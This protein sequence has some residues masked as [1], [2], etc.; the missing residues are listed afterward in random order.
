MMKSIRALV[1]IAAAIS[2]FAIPALADPVY[3]E[4]DGVS[5]EAYFGLLF[6]PV[7]IL[8]A[9]T[10]ALVGGTSRGLVTTFNKLENAQN[11]GESLEAMYLTPVEVVKSS[12]DCGKI[13]AE[14]P[15]SAAAF[16]A[17]D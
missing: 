13:G 6:A 2:Q 10:G 14:K 7:R 5:R 4:S 1:L 9:A 11:A 17:Q 12:I 3:T 15:F 16:G 8:G